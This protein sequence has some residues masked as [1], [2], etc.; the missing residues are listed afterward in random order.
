MS[1]ATAGNISADDFQS[2]VTAN[3]ATF[4]RK[5]YLVSLHFMER[6]IKR[7]YQTMPNGGSWTNY[8]FDAVRKPNHRPSVCLVTDGMQLVYTGAVDTGQGLRKVKTPTN[9]TAIAIAE[10]IIK[11]AT[12]APPGDHNY[13]TAPAVWISECGSPSDIRNGFAKYR[14]PA[15]SLD[16]TGKT[17]YS[18]EW[19]N[20][21]T[22]EF[23]KAFPEF[24]LEC[25]AMT[26]R[27][28][29]RCELWLNDANAYYVNKDFKNISDL[30]RGAATWVGA[31]PAEYP[32]LED[33][34]HGAVAPCPYC[35]S[36]TSTAHPKC[37]N[38]NEIINRPAYD[39]L[40]AQNAAANASAQP[41]PAQAPP[42]P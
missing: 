35:G 22:A 31:N 14:I 16:R 38:C 39:R 1:T 23:K 36:K 19:D 9:E 40:Q 28:W 5:I 42:R 15:I 17:I 11:E 33:T 32:W 37:G 41:R 24:S 4:G 3:M 8:H 34:S 25:E 18:S 30:H 27:Q 13:Y 21:G 29:R 2:V 7:E 20:Y 12:G 26:R 6:N 10:D